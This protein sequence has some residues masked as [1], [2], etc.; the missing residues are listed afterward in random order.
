MANIE[1]IHFKA[2]G[3]DEGSEIVLL[4]RS[5]FK[6]KTALP[7][8]S[9][10]ALVNDQIVGHILF[11]NAH[12]VGTAKSVSARILAPLA[13]SPEFQNSGI[14]GSLIEKGLQSLEEEGVDLVFVLGHPDYYPR[15]G[16][17]PAGDRGFSAPYPIPEKNA[18]A[19][20]VR[21][22]PTGSA[23]SMEGEV[24]CADALNRP[25]L[26]RE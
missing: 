24:Q 18:E 4:V 26:W 21:T 9:L 15:S 17:K 6:D 19:W 1:Q 23:E 22:L 20:M 25:E 7:L 14:G 10:V 3:S 5:L 16:F 12:I 2:F 11:S 8:L 13:V